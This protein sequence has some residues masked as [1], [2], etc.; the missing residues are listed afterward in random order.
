MLRPAAAPP[1]RE[2]FAQNGSFTAQN[3]HDRENLASTCATTAGRPKCSQAQVY[4]VLGLHHATLG[5]TG[6]GVRRAGTVI[7]FLQLMVGLR[8]FN[9]PYVR[10]EK[11]DKHII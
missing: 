3:K 11:I 10:S 1:S 6:L 7:G 9:I 8:H 2:T 4:S 5:A